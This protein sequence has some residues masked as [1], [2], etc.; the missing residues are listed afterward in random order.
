MN[1]TRFMVLR[2]NSE[3]DISEAKRRHESKYNPSVLGY[4]AP[5]AD[6]ITL[7]DEIS[8]RKAETHLRAEIEM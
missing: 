1:V 4:Q 3:Q 6:G 5:S 7:T 2:I 8:F